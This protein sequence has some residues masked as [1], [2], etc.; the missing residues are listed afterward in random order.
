MESGARIE[1]PTIVKNLFSL[2]DLAGVKWEKF[3][4]GIDIFRLHVTDGA[5]SSALLRY[6]P[7][8][9]LDRHLHGGW[10]HILVL[11]GSQIDDAGLHPVGALIIHSPGSS[12]AIESPQGCIVLAIWE[13]PV[14]FLSDSGSAD[15]LEPITAN[16]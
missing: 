8:A 12:H 15:H 1:N 14:K 6:A 2:P 5:S 7:G 10:E 3:R 11:S 16:L 13:R 9:T 4:K